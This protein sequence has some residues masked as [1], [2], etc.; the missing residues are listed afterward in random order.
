MRRTIAFIIATA[1]LTVAVTFA[2]AHVEP[3]NSLP[4]DNRT[5][6]LLM[7]GGM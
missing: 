1:A 7:A 6:I 3:N 4:M 2:T 5:M